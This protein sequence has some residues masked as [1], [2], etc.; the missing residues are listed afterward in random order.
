M[1]T[2]KTQSDYG[3]NTA[4]KTLLEGI[5]QPKKKDSRKAF[6]AKTPFACLFVILFALE[7]FSDFSFNVFR[8]TTS[9]F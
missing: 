5:S 3:R 6:A 9:S 1:N 4:Y 7:L 8:F 2:Q